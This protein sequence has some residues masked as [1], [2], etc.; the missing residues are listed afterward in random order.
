MFGNPKRSLNF[1]VGIGPKD[2]NAIRLIREYGE[3]I[4]EDAAQAVAEIFE[5]DAAYETA[6][7]RE[8]SPVLYVWA[9]PGKAKNIMKLLRAMRPDALEDVGGNLI[10][11]WWG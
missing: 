5:A 4:G 1:R 6:F 10:R 9:K 8:N 11:A 7:G 2:G 3:F